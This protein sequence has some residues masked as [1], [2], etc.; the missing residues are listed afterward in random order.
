MDGQYLHPKVGLFDPL[1]LQLLVTIIKYKKRIGDTFDDCIS[2]QYLLHG[3][4]DYL[5]H[6]YPHLHPLLLLELAKEYKE[7]PYLEEFKWSK[8]FKV[9]YTGYQTQDTSEMQGVCCLFYNLIYYP[10]VELI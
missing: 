2:V 6:H 10:S 3:F 7:I 9:V 5:Q 4:Q 8:P 1:L